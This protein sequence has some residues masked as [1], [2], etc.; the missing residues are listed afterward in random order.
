MSTNSLTSTT[1]LREYF[2]KLPAYKANGTNWIFFQ[3]CFFF[4]V[5]TAG[6]SDYFDD[7]PT[8]MTSEPTEPQVADPTKPTPEEKEAF[9]Q[10]PLIKCIW[11]SEQAIIKQGIASVIPDSLFLKVKGEKTAKEMWN[12]VKAEYEK[13]SKMVTV[14]MQRKMQDEKCPEGDVKAH[15]TKLQTI[16]EE[17]IAMGTNPGD[18][19]FVAIVLGSLP[20]SYKTYLSALTGAVCCIS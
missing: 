8:G 11:K 10:Y 15:L 7:G 4:A 5:D 20:A 19:N 16:R 14:Y 3:D 2:A 6:L 18:E 17:L 13:K 9:K 12:K 1:K